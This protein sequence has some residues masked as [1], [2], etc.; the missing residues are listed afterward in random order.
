MATPD[1]ANRVT[2]RIQGVSAEIGVPDETEQ[3]AVTLFGQLADDPNF[4]LHR[5]DPLGAS[6]LV[7]ACRRDG[8]PITVSDV[9]ESWAEVAD[10]SPGHFEP[11]NVYQRMRKVKEA[12]GM[13]ALPPSPQDLIDR[14]AAELGLPDPL[15]DAAIRLLEDASESDSSVGGAGK[16][17]SGIAA[18]SVYLA[19]RIN[20]RRMDFP[21]Y[22]IAAVADVSEV[23][24]RNRY[25]HLAELLG[26]EEQLSSDDRYTVNTD[27][28]SNTAERS[29]AD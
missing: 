13:G 21:Q 20:D 15:A 26:G 18:G 1:T 23:T 5:A 3:T 19:A 29:S 28:S 8:L 24:I 10:D 17:P 7:I 4:D 16:S 2:E 9:T 25:Q 11:S 27:A 14:F 12:T 6:V 22:E